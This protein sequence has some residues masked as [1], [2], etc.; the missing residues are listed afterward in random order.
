MSLNTECQA[1]IFMVGTVNPSILGVNWHEVPTAAARVPNTQKVICW[2]TL[3]GVQ[4][5]K[6]R[7]MIRGFLVNTAEACR[8]SSC[9]KHIN[10]LSEKKPSH[11]MNR[12]KRTCWV[13][14]PL[15]MNVLQT[16]ETNHHQKPMSSVNTRQKNKHLSKFSYRWRCCTDLK[17]A[18]NKLHYDLIIQ[19]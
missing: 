19:S 9:Q 1:E 14:E 13:L 15:V 3:K 2:T 10:V 18:R 12:Q 17:S 11:D 7:V 4:A 6:R 5:T 8:H 16:R